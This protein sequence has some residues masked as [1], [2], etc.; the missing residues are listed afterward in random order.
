M[1]TAHTCQTFAQAGFERR[2]RGPAWFSTVISGALL[3]PPCHDA[4][5]SGCSA[6]HIARGLGPACAT[7]ETQEIASQG[8]AAIWVVLVPERW[9]R[10]ASLKRPFENRHQ[11]PFTEQSRQ[12][13]YDRLTASLVWARTRGNVRQDHVT[14]F[15]C[16]GNE[17]RSLSL[18]S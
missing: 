5:L 2:L 1:M 17:T 18:M 11:M 3:R 14:A 16:I 4:R 9:T 13:E 12:A 7:A 10:A 6:W 8:R 15:A